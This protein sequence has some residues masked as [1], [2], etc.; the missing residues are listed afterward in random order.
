L[1]KVKT[2]FFCQHCGYMSPK[3]L[4]KCPSCSE[5][6]CFAEELVSE[7]ES[8]SRAEMQFDGKPLPIA[9]IPAEEGERTLT[10]L[11][12]ID[13]VLGGGIVSG[14]AILVGGE[15]GIGKSTLMLQMMKKLASNGR[16]VLY[17]SGEESAHQIKLRSNRIDASTQNLQDLLVLVEVS[18]DKILDQVNRVQPSI[19][20]IDSI[21]TVY[22]GDLMSA[23]GSVG[24]VRESSSRL[25]LTA[26]KNGIPLFLIGHVTKDGSIAGP[27]VLEHMVDTVLY[28][29]GDSGHAYRIIRAIK[30]RFG[31]T[32][33]IGVFEMMDQGL[34]EVD[35]PSA[36][37]LAER[38]HNAPGSVVVSSLEGTRPI[39]VEIQALVSQSNLGVPRRTS[40]GVD[41][42]RVSLLVAVLDK[43]CGLNLGGS[44]I[45]INV[46]GGVRVEEP[47]VDLGVVSAMASSFLDRPVDP[48]TIILGEVGLTGEVRA[49]SQMDVRIRESVRLGFNRCIVPSSNLSSL[50]KKAKIEIHPIR[51]LKDLLENLF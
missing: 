41:H 32:N 13:R 2:S 48:G 33:E 39:L 12:E 34:R 31:P 6:N 43:I 3:W 5:W 4:G 49:V 23:P 11:A 19:V 29:E 47:A 24:Q 51:S 44:D 35:N 40:I 45:F 20:V 17:V 21:Q 26:K 7:P 1:K 37:F 10:G 16:K 46:A 8:G 15:P 50:S 42:N 18:L 27:K 38:P 30:N 9:E 28:F 36:F 22:S 25:I 14:S